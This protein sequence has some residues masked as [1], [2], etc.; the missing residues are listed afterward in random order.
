MVTCALVLHLLLDYL[1]RVQLCV[2]VYTT[3]SGDPYIHDI[4]IKKNVKGI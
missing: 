2:Y 4:L 1:E 3:Y